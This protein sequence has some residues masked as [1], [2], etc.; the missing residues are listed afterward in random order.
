MSNT[1]GGNFSGMKNGD[2]TTFGTA[3]HNHGPASNVGGDQNNNNTTTNNNT[4]SHNNSSKTQV[5]NGGG[6]QNA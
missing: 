2:N 3:T 5:M 4:N 1:F 6:T